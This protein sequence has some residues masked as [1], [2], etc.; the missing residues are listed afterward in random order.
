MRT[1]D[2]QNQHQ[3]EINNASQVTVNHISPTPSSLITPIFNPA[4]NV[5]SRQLDHGYIIDSMGTPKETL[6]EELVLSKDVSELT[7]KNIKSSVE[8]NSGV[9]MLSADRIQNN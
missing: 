2:E 9:P 1:Q 5:A 6:K 4:S 8:P 7:M 3:Q